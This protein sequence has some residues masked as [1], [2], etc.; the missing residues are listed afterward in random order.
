MSWHQ[1]VCLCVGVF[2]LLFA[3]A[4]I[5]YIQ[6]RLTKAEFRHFFFLAVL[7]AAGAVFLTVVGLTYTGES[8]YAHTVSSF[9]H[10][11][12]LRTG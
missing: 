4:A 12:F 7:G 1:R 2:C 6:S 11:Y 5:V 3:Y 8:A 9:E 10:S